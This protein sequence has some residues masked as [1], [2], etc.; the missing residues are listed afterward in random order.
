MKS[1][2]DELLAEVKAVGERQARLDKLEVIDGDVLAKT[3]FDDPKYV[4]NGILPD[5][6]IAVCA[7]SKAAGKTLLL[8]QLADAITKG[9]P[10]MGVETAPSTV[11]FLELELSKRRTAQRLSKMGITPNK[12]LKFAWQWQ[13]GEAGIRDLTDYVYVKK[14]QLVVVDVLQRLW[15][16]EQDSNSYG[17]AYN[18]LGPLRAMANELNVM[19]LLVTHLRKAEATDYMNSVI[20]SVGITANADVILSLKRA[21]GENDAVLSIDGNDVESK[22]IAL[23]FSPNPL[24][25][26]ESDADP[27]MAG[28]T[29]ERKKIVQ[30]ITDLGG[31]ARISEI[32]EKTGKS[33]PNVSKLVRKLVE[34]GMLTTVKTGTYALIT[35]K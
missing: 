18:V 28:Q 10:F 35:D 3:H 7:A 1:G 23:R 17:D 12:N 24:G 34:T 15:P 33:Q 16:P 14:I 9:H 19:V 20:G 11:L 8:L 21:R 27:A 25:F 4:W 30:A 22:E 29:R 6:G 31:Q 5:S 13:Q 26:E 32:V 2:A